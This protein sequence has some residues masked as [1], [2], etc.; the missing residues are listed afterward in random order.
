MSEPPRTWTM[1]GITRPNYQENYEDWCKVDA[2]IS[3]LRRID[4][5]ED[6]GIPTGDFL[7]ILR[8]FGYDIIKSR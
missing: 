3:A 1:C 5:D 7:T 6:H 8:R 4:K 2:V